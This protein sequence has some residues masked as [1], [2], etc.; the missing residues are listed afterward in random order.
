MEIRE[1]YIPS[2][3]EFWNTLLRNDGINPISEIHVTENSIFFETQIYIYP[4]IQF[5]L[6]DD[7]VTNFHLSESS[8]L[9][10]VSVMARKKKN[11]CV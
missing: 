11:I 10:L 6:V 8:L 3:Q 7:L 5:L 9:V 4:G 2:V 1:S